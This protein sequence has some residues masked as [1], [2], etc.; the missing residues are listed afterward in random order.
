MA[1]QV[2]FHRKPTPQLHRSARGTKYKHRQLRRAGPD[3][4]PGVQ[5]VIYAK[6]TPAKPLIEGSLL[7][8]GL[9]RLADPRPTLLTHRYSCAGLGTQSYSTP[10]RRAGT[11]HGHEGT[12]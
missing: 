2:G 3:G 10:H 9:Y 5:L 8:L 6:E 12:H 7:A 1:Q 11:H 4:P